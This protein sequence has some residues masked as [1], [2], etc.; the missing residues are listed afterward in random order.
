[1]NL[2]ELD[3]ALRQLRLSGMAA[4]L[5]TRLRQAQTEKMV[6]LDLVSALVTDELRRR[7]DRPPPWRRLPWSNRAE[8]QPTELQPGRRRPGALADQIEREIAILRLRIVVEHLKPIDDRADRA[9]EIVAD[10]RT[11]QRCK[12]EGIGGGTG[13]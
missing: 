13:R 6:P 5:E 10:A 7:Q 1:M 4:V 3:R 2:V 11:Q 12:L 9:D 8:C